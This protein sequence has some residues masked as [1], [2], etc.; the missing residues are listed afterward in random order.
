M[1]EGLVNHAC[2]GAGRAYRH[3]WDLLELP[4]RKVKKCW[5]GPQEE[6]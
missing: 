3:T 5:V 2:V 1:Q 6:G 4:E